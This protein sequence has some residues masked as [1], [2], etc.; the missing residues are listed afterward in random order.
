MSSAREAYQAIRTFLREQDDAVL[1]AD[2][3]IFKSDMKPG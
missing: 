2:F 3:R 1:T